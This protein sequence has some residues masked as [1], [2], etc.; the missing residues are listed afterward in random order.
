M[1]KF[2]TN[3]GTGG[4]G[5][6]ACLFLPG[7]RLVESSTVYSNLLLHGVL[8]KSITVLKPGP[9]TVGFVC[10]RVPRY[11]FRCFVKTLTRYVE[12]IPG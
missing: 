2:V 7:L 1:V 4:G 3:A 5:G 12:I 9:H 8:V 10:S 6:I 11:G